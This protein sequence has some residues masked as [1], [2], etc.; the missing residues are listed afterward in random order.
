MTAADPPVLCPCRHRHRHDTH[1]IPAQQRDGSAHTGVKG[2]SCNQTTRRA[3]PL[4]R[5][6]SLIGLIPACCTP[7]HTA[8]YVVIPEIKPDHNSRRIIRTSPSLRPA[9]PTS[10]T[11]DYTPPPRRRSVSVGADFVRSP[12]A[13]GW[14]AS[15]AGACA[16]ARVQTTPAVS[17]VGRPPPPRLPPLRSAVT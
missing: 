13:A 17:M 3:Q 14:G 16:R 9:D 10:P 2:S 11:S 4:A 1:K 12:D 15:A 5:Q 7:H 6:R 8:S